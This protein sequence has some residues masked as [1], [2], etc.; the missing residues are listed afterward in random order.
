MVDRGSMKIWELDRT[1]GKR[2][3][4]VNIPVEVEPWVKCNWIINSD[5]DLISEKTDRDITDCFNSND[6]LELEFEEVK[7]LTGYE[8]VGDSQP[9]YF[10]DG[11]KEICSLQEDNSGGRDNILYEKGNYFSTYSAA[12]KES[13]IIGLYQRMK[14]F[15]I[16]NGWDDSMLLDGRKPKH[17]MYMDLFKNKLVLSDSPSF[18]D[19][20]Q[21]YFTSKEIAKKAI[22]Q[23]GQ[24]WIDIY[25][26]EGR[27]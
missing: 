11:F 3:K 23:F 7:E 10:I 24:E 19:T 17:S 12:E 2:Y 21:V 4:I 14:R 25:K 8:R 9:F 6:L 5:K 26:K 1:K 27:E 13:K 18:P 16:E 15:S 22:E 20:F